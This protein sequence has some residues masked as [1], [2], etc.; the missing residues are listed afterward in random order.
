MKEKE[1]KNIDD[2][3]AQWTNAAV[4]VIDVRHFV[5]QSQASWNSYR[6]PASS[7]FYACKGR[8]TVRLNGREY[9]ADRFLLLHGGKGMVLDV[10]LTDER[11]VFYLILYKAKTMLPSPADR[12]LQNG[13]SQALFQLPYALV[14]LEPTGLYDL[15]VAMAREW[16]AQER[17]RA[18]GTFLQFVHEVMQQLMRHG[19]QQEQEPLARRVVRFLEEHYRTRISLESLAEHFCYSARYLTRLV[20]EETGHSP[21]DYVI[22]LRMEKAKELLAG[23]DATMQEIAAF[24]GYQDVLYFSRLFKKHTG[25]TPSAFSGQALTTPAVPDRPYGKPGLSIVDE[26]RGSYSV[27]DNRY[28]RSFGGIVRMNKKSTRHMAT[29]FMV[30]LA[31]LVSA[32]SGTASPTPQAGESVQEQTGTAQ[33][34]LTDGLGNKVTVPAQ[35]QRIIASYL[36]DHLVALGVKPVAQWSI[37]DGDVQDYLQKDLAGIPAIPYDLPPEVV[38]SY[39]PDLIIMDNAEMVAGDKYSQYAKISPTYT[40]GKE[41]NSD[42]R[43]ELLIVGEVLNKSEEAKKVLA[44]YDAYVA[45][46]KEKLKQG[47]GEKSAAALWVTAKA[48]YMARKDLSSGDVLYKDLGFKVPGVVEEISKSG[49]AN[50]NAV[51]LEKLAELDA[52]YLFVV[53]SKGV[54]KDELLKEPVWANIPAVKNGQV[55]DFTTDSSWLYTGVIANRQMIE[56]VLDNVLK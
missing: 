41:K 32:C 52:D 7:F 29:L 8:A 53:N 56:D 35:P 2:L 16:E 33:R 38:M 50:W 27:N 30:S 1:K 46:S 43:K 23:T 22:S 31:L 42:W 17:L 55:F 48:V 45:E 40:I 14:P 44:D 25:M 28:Q 5:L 6:L 9:A 34:E 10:K 54:S 4:Q 20:K 11:F 37:G 26:K 21:I 15:V 49:E 3:L 19:F 51:S 13:G 12:T 36:E 18:K 39:N 47:I 24:V